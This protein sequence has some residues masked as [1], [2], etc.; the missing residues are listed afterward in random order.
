MNASSA[1]LRLR[2][3]SKPPLLRFLD[4]CHAGFLRG[5]RRRRCRLHSRAQQG[6]PCPF[7]H[8]PRH[9]RRP[10]LR[11]RRQ[12]HPLHHPVDVKAVRVRT[13]ARH[14]G[15]RASRERDRRRTLGD[16]FNSIRLNADNHPF[17]PMVNAGAIACSGLIHE[18]KGDAA[19]DHIRARAW[20]F[21]RARRSRSTR[22]SMPRKAQ[23]ATATAPL[24]ICCAPMRCIKDRVDAVLDV[25]F[26]QCA[27]WSR[28]ATSP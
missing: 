17:N 20:P 8:Q 9:A 12:Q 16:P 7:W 15:R 23:P 22:P 18:A 10:C 19:F 11:G 25:Y 3:S 28:R 5:E 21:C 14:A 2:A 13:G 1:R 24:P 26:R 4:R 27:S 6:R